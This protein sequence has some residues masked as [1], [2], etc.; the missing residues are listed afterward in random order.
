MHNIPNHI[1]ITMDGNGRWAKAKG[2]PRHKGHEE[3]AKTAKKIVIHAAKTGIKH[4]TLYSFSYE[5][6][7]RPEKEVGFLMSLLKFY[8]VDQ[9]DELNEAGVKLKVIGEKSRLSDDI[10]KLIDAA[11]KRTSTNATLNLQIAFS[12]G[13]RQEILNAVKLSG[14][15]AN[16]FT[17]NLYTHG[18]P[19]PDLFIRTGGEHRISNFL[20]WQMA[21]TEL[22]FIDKF[23]PDFTESDFD[24]AI[25]NYSKRERRFGTA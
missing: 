18:T 20:L 15:D 23:W 5:N 1:A 2:L 22:Y 13:G 7:N 9:I 25:N 21:Y 14:G 8:L 11:E 19:D 4:L 6:W 16:A 12:Y 17:Q 10:Q 3:G 24:E